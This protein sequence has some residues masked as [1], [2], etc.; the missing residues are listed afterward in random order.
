MAAPSTQE[1]TV[2]LPVDLI[3]TLQQVARERR[4]SP[5]EIVAEALR[6]SLEPIRQQALQQLRRQVRQQQEQSEPEIRAHLDAT[7]SG[8]EQDRLSQLLELNR[9][10]ELTGEEQRELQALFDRI[11]EVATAKAAAIW[12][13]SSN[14]ASTRATE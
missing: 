7:L 9:T 1:Y 13:L 10:R 3:Q 14:S 2:R 11:E 8:S 6:F 5:D 4:E 12:L